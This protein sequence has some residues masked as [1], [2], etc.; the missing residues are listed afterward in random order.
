M[1]TSVEDQRPLVC[2]LK[3]KIGHD[4]IHLVY[5]FRLWAFGLDTC[6]DDKKVSLCCLTLKDAL[7]L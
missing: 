2:L 6:P 5:F 4:F 7:S 1:E 3:S